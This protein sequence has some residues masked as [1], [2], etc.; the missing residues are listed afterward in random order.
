MSQHTPHFW[1]NELPPRKNL[2]PSSVY[3]VNNGGCVTIYVTSNTGNP[4]PVCSTTGGLQPGDNVSLLINDAGYITSGEL[5][6]IRSILAGANIAIDDSDPQNPQI[7]VTGLGSAA[8]LSS[9]S[10]ATSQQGGLADTA[11]Q[12]GDV[13]TDLSG[14]TD[15]TNLLF[16]GNYQ[17]LTNTPNFGAVAY[18]NDYNDLDNKPTVGGNTDLTY[19]TSP[20]QGVVNSS[21]GTDA[22]IPLADSTNAGLFSPAE[23]TKLSA[24]NP[25]SF[26]KSNESLAQAQRKDDTLYGILDQYT[27][28]DITLSKVTGTPTVDS[29]IYFQMGSEYFKRNSLLEINVKW[30]GAKGDGVT[31]DTPSIQQAINACDLNGGGIVYFP[32]GIYFID[33]AKDSNSNSQIYFPLNSL[34]SSINLKCIRLR[35]QTPPNEYSNPFFSAGEND[36]PNSSVILKS[37]MLSSGNIIGSRSEASTWGDFNFIHA[38]IENISVR[39]RSMTGATNVTPLATGIN[40][41]NVALYTGKYIEVCTTSQMYATLEPSTTCNG[42]IMPRN[43]NFAICNMD[44]FN[45]YGVNTAVDCYEHTHLDNFLIDTCI[46]GL[47]FNNVNHSIHVTKGCVARSRYNITAQNFSYFYVDHISFENDTAKD[48][49]TPTWNRTLLDLYDVEGTSFGTVRVHK[50]RA[51][52]GADYTTFLRNRINSNI[53]FIRISELSKEFNPNNTQSPAKNDL[54]AYWKFEEATGSFTDASGNSKTATRVNGATTGAG[55]IGNAM[56]T[57]AS[58]EQYA[59]AGTTGLSVTA[60]GISFSGWFRINTSA[61]EF[62]VLLNKGTSVVREYNLYYV[63]STNSL[64]LVAY[65]GTTARGQATIGTIAENTW[66]HVYGEITASSVKLSVNNVSTANVTVSGALSADTATD[67]LIGAGDSPGS[68]LNGGVDELAVF[69]RPLTSGEREYIYNGSYANAIVLTPTP[70]ISEVNAL[71]TRGIATFTGDNSTTS[72][73]FPH[74]LNGVPI[75]SVTRRQDAD[76]NTFQSEADATNINVTFVGGIPMSGNVTQVNWF[77]I[78][79]A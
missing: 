35:G 64:T 58:S 9:N 8:F 26:I 72:F 10:F 63:K 71:I 36:H 51:G 50:V 61:N 30:F 41:G 23:K 19:T 44:N 29:V 4:I 6:G 43:N 24:I 27:G 37:N 70:V 76:A 60:N 21:T 75:V 40:M 78:L 14:F 68:S 2:C 5:Q 25:T 33:G 47:N 74:G 55:K 39:I 59:N 17:D 79:P 48:V 3:F 62:Q 69:K 34:S 31:N 56:L 1:V 77:A 16:S 13:P 7:S 28:E 57:L 65:G 38:K 46:A 22:T 67:L 11:L 73:S 12:P 54:L 20:S 32:N 42:V 45:I 49:A 66:M 15:N 52:V 53:K 18:S